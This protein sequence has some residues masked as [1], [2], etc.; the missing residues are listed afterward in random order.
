[1]RNMRFV[2]LLIIVFGAV[3]SPNTVAG[4]C[5]LFVDREAVCVPPYFTYYAPGPGDV[6]EFNTIS[7]NCSDPYS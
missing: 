4:R 1:M 6:N 3:Y 7:G 2:L 5:T